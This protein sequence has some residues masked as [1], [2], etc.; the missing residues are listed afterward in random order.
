MASISTATLSSQVAPITQVASQP[1]K[2]EEIKK[3]D[4]KVENDDDSDADDDVPDLAPDASSKTDNK[5]NNKANRH[6]NDL[7]DNDLRSILK[8]QNGGGDPAEQHDLLKKMSKMSPNKINELLKKLSSDDDSQKQNKHATIGISRTKLA[9]LRL[10]IKLDEKKAKKA[11]EDMLA[12]MK[13]KK[14]KKKA[15]VV[16]VNNDNKDNKDASTSSVVPDH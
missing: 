3:K 11:E 6:K 1:A 16:R 5:K 13:K 4:V 15:K 10:R 14:K 2:L 7:T 8:N 12:S 9:Q